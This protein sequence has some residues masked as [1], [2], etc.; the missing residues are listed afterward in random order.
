MLPVG[1]GGSCAGLLAGL[2]AAG[3]D[4]PVVGVSVSR[5]PAEARTAVLGLAREC[6]A[7]RGTAAPDAR[8]AGTGRRP[9]GGLRPRHELERERARLALHTEGLLLDATYGAEAFTVA[10]D[11]LRARPLGTRSCGGTPAGVVPGRRATRRAQPSGARLPD[12]T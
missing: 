1:S 6:A 8:A 5:P 12:A 10:L 2:A 9:R 7:L 11:R 4:I 3:L